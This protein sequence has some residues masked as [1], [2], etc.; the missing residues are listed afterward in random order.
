M[1]FF[2]NIIIT[3]NVNDDENYDGIKAKVIKLLKMKYFLER[4]SENPLDL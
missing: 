2:I 4:I 3:F 1:L